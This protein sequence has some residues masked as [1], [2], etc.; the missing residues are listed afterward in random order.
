MPSEIFLCGT[1]ILGVKKVWFALVNGYDNVMM[2]YHILYTFNSDQVK[3][4]KHNLFLPNQKQVGKRE[5]K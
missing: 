3:N 2:D 1:L 5:F 4:F